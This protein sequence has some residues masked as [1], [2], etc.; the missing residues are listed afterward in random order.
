MPTSALRI[1]ALAPLARD[2][3][4][5]RASAA[6]QPTTLRLGRVLAVAA[7]FFVAFYQ[8]E[9]DAAEFAGA[10]VAEIGEDRIAD[11]YMDQIEDGSTI[12]K[13]VI[14][15]YGMLGLASLVFARDRAWN[16]RPA[17]LV[18]IAA[19]L[20]WAAL[21]SSWS[22]EPGLSRKRLVVAGLILTGSL[23]FA[24]LLRPNELLM[25]ALLTF[26]AFVGFSLTADVAAGGRPWES[27]YRFTGTLHPNIQAAY[28]GLLCLAAFC[29]PAPFGRRWITRGLLAFGVLALVATQ[30]RTSLLALAVGFVMAWLISLG[31]RTRWLGASLLVSAAAV[32]TIVVSSLGDGGRRRLT[33]AVLLGRTEQASSLTGRVPLWEE[34]AG[35]AATRPLTGYGYETFWTPD[36]IAEVMKSQQWALQSAHNGYFELVL[37]L[38]WVGLAL[39][40]AFVLSGA[41]V[42][43]SAYARRPMAGYAFAYGVIGFALVNSLLESHF[44]KLKYPTVVALIAVLGAACFF[45]DRVA[46]D[47]D[48]RRCGRAAPQRRNPSRTRRRCARGA[49]VADERRSA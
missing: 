30:S 29:Q 26:T 44:A 49:E 31:G 11:T 27:D 48:G 33:D 9:H 46:D 42:L 20:A 28:C 39:A 13:L 14:V 19:L 15:A 23:G 43:Q 41:N 36:R 35:Y 8:L 21:S 47:E 12:R 18:M 32:A 40:T 34:L 10:Q 5:N 6:E 7:F 25:V 37:Q 22:V 4:P 1:P 2:A 3:S 45:P 38:G 16:V 24:R 17:T